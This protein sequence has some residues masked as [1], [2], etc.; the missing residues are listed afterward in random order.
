MAESA[1]K[2]LLC[3]HDFLSWISR[4]QVNSGGVRARICDP[5]AGE[6]EAGRFAGQP[7]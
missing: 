2:C 1:V 4:T 3:K 5:S 6:A 7:A